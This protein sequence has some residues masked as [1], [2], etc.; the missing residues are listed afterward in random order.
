MKKKRLYVLISGAGADLLFFGQVPLSE[1][2]DV[3]DYVLSQVKASESDV[4]VRWKN[5]F[6][7]S[8]F[9]LSLVKKRMIL[10]LKLQW[11][12]ELRKK[13]RFFF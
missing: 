7:L 10:R 8:F 2:K 11:K 9:T 5:L 1:Y 12:K 3:S 6:F 4:E 13:K